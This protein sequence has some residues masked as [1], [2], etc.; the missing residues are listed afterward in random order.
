MQRLLPLAM[1]NGQWAI[2]GILTA[3]MDHWPMSAGHS[4]ISVALSR[5]ACKQDSLVPV[6][7]DKGGISAR[8]SS[9]KLDEL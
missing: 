3:N 9:R 6:G 1:G 7:P 5:G 8:A 2:D 4:V